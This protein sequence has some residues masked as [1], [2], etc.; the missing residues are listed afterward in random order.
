M[1]PSNQR[2]VD[3][4]RP[5]QA[6]VHAAC[7][8]A[9][10]IGLLGLF[11]ALSATPNDVVF[12][13]FWIAAITFACSVFII[14]SYAYLRFRAFV[15]GLMPMPTNRD[16]QQKIEVKKEESEKSLE[17]QLREASV[18]KQLGWTA[19]VVALSALLVPTFGVAGIIAM[20]RVWRTTWRALTLLPDEIEE[21]TK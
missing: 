13:L 21:K 8:S 16:P 4:D 19:G 3:V 1:I 7:V 17:E 12:A 6:V 9:S 14:L 18:P 10:A 5:P 15:I 11:H 20:S 2:H